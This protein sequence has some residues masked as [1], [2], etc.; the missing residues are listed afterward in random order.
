MWLAVEKFLIPLPILTENTEKKNIYLKPD[1]PDSH[2]FS[3]FL[4]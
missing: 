1:L 4:Q 2:N 3:Y